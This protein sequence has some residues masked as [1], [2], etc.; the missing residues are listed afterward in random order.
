MCALIPST[1][2]TTGEWYWWCCFPFCF[3]NE[4]VPK[5]KDLVQEYKTGKEMLLLGSRIR[6]TRQS[7]NSAPH[8]NLF[9]DSQ[10]LFFFFFEKWHNGH[11]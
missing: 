4:N 7:Q 3:K 1:S 8:D 10:E 2:Y 9:G 11:A 5:L 6:N